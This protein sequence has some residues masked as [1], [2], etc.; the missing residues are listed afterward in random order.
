MDGYSLIADLFKSFVTMI[1]ALAWPAA[2]FATVWLFRKRLGDLL[3]LLRAKYKDVEISFR[4]HK[5]EE[6]VKK[7]PPAPTSVDTGTTSEEKNRFEQLARMSPRAAI[8]EARAA[9]EEAVK[10]FAGAVGVV[11]PPTGYANL[12]R[13]LAR[14]ELIDQ[15]TSALLHDLRNIGN[16]AAHHVSN[17]TEDDALRFNELAER[18][19]NQLN[20]TAL[21][22]K[23]PPPRP[24]PPGLP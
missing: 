4:L 18:V 15:N 5:A 9:L 3:P 14:N 16:A 2:I 7:L 20:V 11:Q 17:P 12:I 6:E 10:S 22:A 19:I 1:A 24:I 8:L 21:A 23:M 13:L